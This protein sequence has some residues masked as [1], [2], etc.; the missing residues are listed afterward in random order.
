M[1]FF[2]FKLINDY[3]STLKSKNANQKLHNETSYVAD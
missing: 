1:T 3:V 2:L